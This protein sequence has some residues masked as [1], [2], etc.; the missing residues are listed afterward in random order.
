VLNIVDNDSTGGG[1]GDTFQLAT[2][3]EDVSEGNG[4]ETV[5]I[6]RT[7]STA[8]GA[9]VN[10]AT[11]N[12]SAVQPGDYTQTSGTASF[13]AGDIF[14]AVDIPVIDD[15][16]P[17]STESF[18]IGLSSPSAGTIGSTG[19]QQVNIIDNDSA[20]TFEFAEATYSVAENSD[21]L[22]VTVR[23][24][25]ALGTNGTTVHLTT[26]DGTATAGSDYT[27]A[28]GD[29]LFDQGDVSQTIAIPIINDSLDETDETIALNLSDDTHPSWD[30]A[31]ATILD[32]D[33]T[34][35]A[36]DNRGG[37]NDGV[38]TIVVNNNS[39]STAGNDGSQAVLG[40]RDGACGLTAKVSKKQKLLKQRVLKLQLKTKRSCKV[41]L[42]AVIKQLKSKKGARSA[43]ALSFKGKKASLTLQPGK[44]K[45]VKVKFT[46]KTLKAI[47]KALQARKKLVATV[48][49]T[50]KDSAS[51]V[52]RKTLKITIRR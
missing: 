6:L 36:S 42:A 30:T 19:N 10:Y 9:T 49:V 21:E 3:S 44:A 4:K 33:T 39:P 48:V 35:P 2:A 34:P 51:N 12:G 46:K 43:K 50:S 52:A 14:Q 20:A 40:E 13:A 25:G 15:S 31:T 23:A 17:E 26:A 38:T 37:D 1:A 41:S 45:T 22:L 24:T 27:D 8:A 28:S 11:A 7:G 29:L 5:Y 32:D 16:N 18:S 47:K